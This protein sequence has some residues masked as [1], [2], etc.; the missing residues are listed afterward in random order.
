LR[1]ILEVRQNSSGRFE[2][3][4]QA[5]DSRSAKPFEG[6]LELVGLLEACL[7]VPQNGGL[8]VSA[9]KSGDSP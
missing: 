5:P 6:I 2:G 7:A 3:S 8:G 1:I 4:V 9:E